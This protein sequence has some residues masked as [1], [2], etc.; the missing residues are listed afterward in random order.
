[1]PILDQLRHGFDVTK[2]KANQLMRIN[3]VQSEISSMRH[4][5]Q[6]LR[7]KI[8]N[9]VISLHR[10]NSLSYPDLEDLCTAIDKI[11]AQIAEKQAQITVIRAETPPQA[12]QP[13]AAGPSNPC[14]NCRFNIP[15]GA[16]FCP[17]CGR[18][19]PTPSESVNSAT[20]PNTNQCSK[21]GFNFSTGATFCP[22][23]QNPVTPVS[24]SG[25]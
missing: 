17:N 18:Q 7:E 15:T 1:M 20:P 4:E 8:A 2:W 23:C 16:V 19:L 24:Q 12:P 22:N 21:C 11:E 9:S 14:P 5:T 6:S 13:I 10:Q 25:A 3:N